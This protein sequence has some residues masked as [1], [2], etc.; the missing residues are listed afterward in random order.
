[1][2]G[3][4][5]PTAR[6]GLPMSRNGRRH[7]HRRAA[8]HR[9]AATPI[10][11]DGDIE[12]GAVDLPA[13]SPRRSEYRSDAG[14]ARAQARTAIAVALAGRTVRAG[15]ADRLS[16]Q[17]RGQVGARHADAEACRRAMSGACCTS[18][19][20]NSHCRRSTASLAGGRIAGDLTFLRRAEGL[21]AR[22]RI[23]LAGA[24]A[25]ELLPGDGCLAAG[26]RSMSRPRAPA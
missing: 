14:A 22:S 25:A 21:T 8:R 18:A 4:P 1:M 20:R 11:L 13:R 10:T 16:G 19:I 26:L 6:C 5:C 7:E 15:L 9:D 17:S 23:K 3:S 12:V 2:R 24:N